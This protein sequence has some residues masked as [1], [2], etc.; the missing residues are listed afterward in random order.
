M[1]GGQRTTPQKSLDEMRQRHLSLVDTLPQGVRML[2]PREA[3]P[4]SRST[5]LQDLTEHTAAV[6]SG[7]GG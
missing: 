3:Y 1:R 4:V 6:V 2:E 5:A 7:D